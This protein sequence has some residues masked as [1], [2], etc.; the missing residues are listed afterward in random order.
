MKVRSSPDG[1]DEGLITV[2]PESL[3]EA[4]QVLDSKIREADSDLEMSPAEGAEKR[5]AL[6][7]L[8]DLHNFMDAWSR[9]PEKM[10]T[11][12]S[13]S[14]DSGPSYL[15][16]AP[17]DVAGPIARKLLAETPA[18]LTSATMQ[19]GGSFNAIGY[20][21]GIAFS[22]EEVE[23]VDVGTPFDPPRQGILYIAE[24]LAPPGRGGVST[25][26]LEELVELAKAAGGGV[27]RCS[28][29]RCGESREQSLREALDV[30][31][32]AQG[33]D[34]IDTRENCAEAL[35][36][37]W[38]ERWRYGRGLTC[39]DGLAAWSRLI[40]S[41]SR[42]QIRWCRLVHATWPNRDATLSAKC[43]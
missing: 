26:A 28:L 10:I 8:S 1:L 39:A 21:T 31:V 24:H 41:R 34:Q 3:V 40:A 27:P 22:D 42:T 5:M 43:P 37:A 7:A 33:E 30:T 23:T 18:I 25:E 38:S 6:S 9:D 36:P 12:V 4:M 17:L 2:R 19:L 13:R 14:D 32:Y 35:I 29:A 20:E 16:C 11:W 15:N